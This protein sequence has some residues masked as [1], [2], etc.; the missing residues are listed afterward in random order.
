MLNVGNPLFGS[1]LA[2]AD[3]APSGTA[4][5]PA[6]AAF[7][8][9]RTAAGDNIT[10]FGPAG[11][12][13]P[14]DPGGFG[15]GSFGLNGFL[16]QF[17]SMIQSAF[18]QLAQLFSQ[19]FG[20]AIPSSVGGGSGNNQQ[21]FTNATASSVGDPHD[22]FNGTML[23]GQVESG[24]WNNMSSH[25]DLLSSNSFPGGFRISTTVGAPNERGV[26]QNDSA[27]ITS[28][29]GRNVITMNQNGTVAVT[30]NGH[31][32]ELPV[33]RT[34]SLG[35]GETA[36]LEPGGKL[37]VTQTNG[38]G[39][40]ITTTLASNGKGGVNVEASAHDV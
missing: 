28:N 30:A 38:Q 16:G 6:P 25:P 7:A 17:M 14:I 32:L 36:T 34:I 11:S 23:G 21:Y 8:S 40:S 20:G 5:G 12:T 29:D 31:T 9:A 15:G 37:S 27:T 19:S 39:G 33:G 4:Q 35:A 1:P 13:I 10:P 22:T 2:S 26:T 3:G 18:S 24:K